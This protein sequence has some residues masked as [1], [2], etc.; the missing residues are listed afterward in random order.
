MPYPEFPHTFVVEL[1][2]LYIIYS[3]FLH[4]FVADRNRKS[5]NGG[6]QISGEK[7]MPLGNRL[8]NLKT[9]VGNGGAK[10]HTN[11]PNLE[12]KNIWENGKLGF[13]NE[14][15]CWKL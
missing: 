10:Y 4:T 5:M 3:E 8:S 15:P 9:L 11:P 7:V 12:K 2:L 14:F 1:Y 6:I 13:A